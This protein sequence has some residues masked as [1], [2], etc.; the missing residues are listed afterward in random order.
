M[1]DLRPQ[2]VSDIIANS[3]G[4]SQ[5]LPTPKSR[6]GIFSA[7]MNGVKS[8]VSTGVSA[9]SGVNP[10]YADLINKQIEVQTQMQ[11]VSLYSNIEKSKHETQM[12]AVRN[13]RAG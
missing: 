2:R 9:F 5:F 7:V 13:I 1:S 11:L 3:A 6:K 8:L 4:L 12:A 10:E